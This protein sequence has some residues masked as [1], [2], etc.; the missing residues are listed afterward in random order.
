[1]LAQPWVVPADPQGTLVVKVA[2]LMVEVR[3]K[4]HRGVLPEQAF[5]HGRP[6]RRSLECREAGRDVAGGDGTNSIAD[7]KDGR[8]ESGGGKA[9]QGPSMLQPHYRHTGQEEEGYDGRWRD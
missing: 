2:S 6:P 1:M 7:S 9:D 3:Q 8:A 5:S 4:C